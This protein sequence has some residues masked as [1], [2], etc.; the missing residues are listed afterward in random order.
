MLGNYV[1]TDLR[2]AVWPSSLPDSQTPRFLS[3]SLSERMRVRLHALRLAYRDY[4]GDRRQDYA[5]VA[6]VIGLPTWF[7]SSPSTFFSPRSG[8]RFGRP[9]R[10]TG[11]CPA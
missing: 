1:R 2:E 5:Q 7:R 6:T 11:P 3:L 8:H 10:T 4:K 9:Q